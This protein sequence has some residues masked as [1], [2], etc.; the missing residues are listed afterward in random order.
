MSELSAEVLRHEFK[1]WIEKI[2]MNEYYD[3]WMSTWL[4]N[5]YHLTEKVRIWEPAKEG[6][7]HDQPVVDHVV[8]M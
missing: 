8:I 6:N 4:M 2:L 5:E 1:R 7:E 3:W